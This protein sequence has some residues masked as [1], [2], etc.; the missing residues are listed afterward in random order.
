MDGEK[1]KGEEQKA[2]VSGP[3][4]QKVTAGPLP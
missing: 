1:E 2:S 3:G 4:D